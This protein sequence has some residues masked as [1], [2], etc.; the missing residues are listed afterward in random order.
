M[1]AIAVA[2]SAVVA[3][4][5]TGLIV[6]QAT[7]LAAVAG[8]ALG[9]AIG[10]VAGS[11]ASQVVG[12]AT[13]N[14]SG[15]NWKGVAMAAIG[16]AIGGGLGKFGALSQAGTAAT[17]TGAQ[18][19]G[20]L[21]KIG[22]FLGKGAFVN[23]AAQGILGNV[24]TQGIGV[25]TGLQ[26]K[27]SWAGVATAGIVAGVSGAVT[28][29]LTP[30]KAGAT[31][32]FEAV[33]AGS[34]VGAVAGAA[35]RS[36]IT[37]TN[38]GDN[39][40]AVLPDVIGSTIGNM[41]VGSVQGSGSKGLA[42]DPA[43][44]TP[45]EA[46]QD[47]FGSKV[48]IKDA[49][50]QS[51]NSVSL[52]IRGEDRVGQ[53]RRSGKPGEVATWE[54]DG[55]TAWPIPPGQERTQ[56]QQGSGG[57]VPSPGSALSAE[58]Q[59][60]ADAMGSNLGSVNLPGGEFFS[61]FTGPLGRYLL[62][63][64]QAAAI[65]GLVAF[66]AVATSR[67]ERINPDDDGIPSLDLGP[68]PAIQDGDFYDDTPHVPANV[69]SEIRQTLRQSGLAV[70]SS[71]SPGPEDPDEFDRLNSEDRA[72][73]RPRPDETRAAMEFQRRTG[74]RLDRAPEGRDWADYVIRGENDTLTDVNF[75]F[76][77]AVNTACTT[78]HEYEFLS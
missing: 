76:C 22:G 66:V 72:T 10:G 34:A 14:Q 63:N 31:P 58:E 46:L 59:V 9:G 48:T 56:E 71:A 18:I 54:T 35:A 24:L 23:D 17:G 32:S 25:A 19:T 49:A 64:P 77:E 42:E 52:R 55:V 61:C 1:I 38:F 26:D 29:G 6:G 39:L 43:S 51:G 12:M 67:S 15:F 8:A 20:T 44:M 36:L 74:L 13:G 62:R 53:F 68:G 16:G 40:I 27:F 69:P 73:G 45:T 60:I 57:S 3:P 78:E 5:A 37:G 4:W 11:V 47:Y 65:T 41:L 2:V 50:Q 28:R 33:Q 70:V 30:N 21:G 75:M 7:G